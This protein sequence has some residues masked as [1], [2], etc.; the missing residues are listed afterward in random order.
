MPKLLG[1]HGTV[2]APGR[3][4]Q[5]LQ[6]ALESAGNQQERVETCLLHLGD[7]QISF[8]DGRPPAN[9]PDDTGKVVEQVIAADMYLI[10]TPIFRASFSASLK[11]LLDLVPV[12][13]L[14]GKPC[15]L[16]GMG[17]TDHHYLAIDT[18][19]RPVLAW[20]G[21]HVVPGEVYLKSSHF[22]DG[23]LVNAAAIAG[24]ESITEAVISAQQA[25]SERS[26]MLGPK[27]LAA[28]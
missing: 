10:A 15:G 4:H 21:A 11:N 12:E 28:S 1:I 13:S 23:W 8:A 22:Q 17:A 18:Q 24:L 26:G 6:L 16:I 19:L 27:P 25:I 20:F 9:Y 5:A 3:L 14:M 2:T 7:H